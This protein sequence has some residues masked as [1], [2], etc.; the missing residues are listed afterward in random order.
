MNWM[1]TAGVGAMMGIF[2]LLFTLLVLR[3]PRRPIR[4]GRF[5]WSGL[6]DRWTR[7]QM[8]KQ[9]LALLSSLDLSNQIRSLL[10][11]P[12]TQEQAE[13]WITDAASRYL[14]TTLPEKWPM[15]S[16]L[17]GD[18]TQEK[19]LNAIREQLRSSWNSSIDQF[20]QHQLQEE[21]IHKQIIQLTRLNQP[22]KWNEMIWSFLVKRIFRLLITF[23]LL[24]A[25][26]AVLGS[27]LYNWMGCL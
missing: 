24:G 17:I 23:L 20:H 27:F 19:V 7:Q 26:M 18:K 21:N 3:Y 6:I 25:M 1:L 10:L 5:Q 14:T 15:V 16:M 9:A 8:E 2:T 13:R 11:K 4:L 12:N 22:A